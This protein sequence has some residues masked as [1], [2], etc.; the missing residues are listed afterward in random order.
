MDTEAEEEQKKLDQELN[1]QLKQLK[2]EGGHKT[3]KENGDA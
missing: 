2:Q 3:N 1:N